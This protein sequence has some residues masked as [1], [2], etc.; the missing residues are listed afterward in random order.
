MPIISPEQIKKPR[1]LLLDFDDDV[2]KFLEE[3]GYNVFSGRSGFTG[4]PFKIDIHDSEIELIFWNCANIEQPE[5]DLPPAFGRGTLFIPSP[6]PT[7]AALDALEKYTGRVRS[8]GGVTVLFLGVKNIQSNLLSTATGRNFLLGQRITTTIFRIDDDTPIAN[9]FKR[10]V[11]EKNIKYSIWWQDNLVSYQEYFVDEDRKHYASYSGDLLIIPYVEDKPS[12]LLVLLQDVLPNLCSDEI[13][14]DLATFEWLKDEDFIMP[15]VKKKI[16]EKKNAE[17]LFMRRIKILAKEIEKGVE[18]N[19]YLNQAL[20]SDDSALF[21]EPKKLKPQVK[22]MLEDLN[23][24]VEDIDVKQKE[25]GKS[26]TEDLQASDGNFL[27]L[28][29]VKGTDQGAKSNWV[30]KDIAAHLLLFCRLRDLKPNEVHS[31]LIFNHERR[32]DPRKRNKP[33]KDDPD[34]VKFSEKSNIILIPVYELYKLCVAVKYN[35]FD[36]NKARELL[37]ASGLFRFKNA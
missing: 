16:M 13:F 21:P 29:E 25:L 12:A 20:V 17:A 32:T 37:K 35:K 30:K 19:N 8:K 33:F 31:M 27:S 18:D 2:K 26:L 4:H 3:E 22:E 6:D 9:F 14:P 1:I 24:A 36:K 23:F 28:I 5:R 34:L 11:D 10:F 15:N 7:K